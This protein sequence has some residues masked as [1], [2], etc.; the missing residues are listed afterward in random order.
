MH[1]SQLT[2]Q[3]KEKYGVLSLQNKP[4]ANKQAT[5]KELLMEGSVDNLQ[6]DHGLWQS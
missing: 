2:Q 5:A 6:G 3:K 1:I 4:P